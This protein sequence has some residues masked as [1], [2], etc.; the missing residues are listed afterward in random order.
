MAPRPPMDRMSEQILEATTIRQRTLLIAPSALQHVLA[1]ARPVTARF[2]NRPAREV[3]QLLGAHSN[4]AVRFTSAAAG[5][6]P[7]NLYFYDAP[8]AD[9]FAFV[10]EA[11]GLTATIEGSAVVITPE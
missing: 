8:A 6:T 1:G 4:V 3:I 11:A 7:V 10:L 2:R 5:A 9:L